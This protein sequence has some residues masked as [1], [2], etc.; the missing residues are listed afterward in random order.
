MLV[1]GVIV[2]LELVNSMVL[3]PFLYGDSAGVSEVGL[4]VAI[5]FWTWLWGPVGLLLATPLTV[6]VV[7]ISKYVPR[8]EF[9]NVLMNDDEVITPDISFYQRLLAM[10][11]GRT[12][13]IVER[14]LKTHPAER[15]Y[16]EVL[17]PAL[18]YA[19]RD[20]SVAH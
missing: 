5:A 17:V 8:L 20:F 1:L 4:L 6:C 18:T 7:V 3:E 16:D 12:R 9:V 11:S 2:A 10:E 19:R 15:I 14:H 13:A